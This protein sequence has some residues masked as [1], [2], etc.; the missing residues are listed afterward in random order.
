MF[1]AHLA[2]VMPFKITSVFLPFGLNNH[3]LG[4]CKVSLE[5]VMIQKRQGPFLFW[6]PSLMV[7]GPVHLGRGV[8]KK[9]RLTWPVTWAVATGTK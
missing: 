6:L 1:W 9:R 4:A 2:S 3:L 8:C 7:S 5:V